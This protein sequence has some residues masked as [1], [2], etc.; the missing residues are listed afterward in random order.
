[1]STP[2]QMT[3][4]RILTG[5]LAVGRGTDGGR[6]GLRIGGSGVGTP[7]TGS[8]GLITAMRLAP[9]WGRLARGSGTAGPASAL[10]AGRLT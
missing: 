4:N 7:N 3:R 8:R 1:M 6:G 10:A 9:R 5:S 2:L